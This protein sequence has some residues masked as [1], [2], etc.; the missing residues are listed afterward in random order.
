MSLE[1][2]ILTDNIW[3]RIS[4]HLSVKAANFGV[5]ANDISRSMRLLLDSNESGP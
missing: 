3:N 2:F 1:R 5:T 4:L